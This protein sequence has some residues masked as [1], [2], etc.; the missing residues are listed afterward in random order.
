V[1]RDERPGRPALSFTPTLDVAAILHI[2]LDVYERRG[3]A[4]H[5]SEGRKRHRTIR[6]SLDDVAGTLT[7]YYNQTDPIPRTTANEQLTQLEER[8]MVRLSWRPGQTDHLLDA[9]ALESDQVEPLYTLLGREPLSDRRHRLHATLL[10][11]RFR[12]DDWR[13][14]AVQHCLDQLQAHKSVAPFNLND[15]DWNRDLL[16][17][18]IALPGVDV[19][20]EIPYRVFS[21]RV[22]ND[23]KRFDALKGA[24][25]RLARRHQPEWHALS[26]RET[27]REL[28]LVANPG[29]LYLYGPWRLVDPHGQV[30]SLSEFYPSVGIPTALAGR[31][32]Q[33]Q[34]NGFPT[35][36]VGTQAVPTNSVETQ[37]ARVVC[38]ENLAPFYELVRHK[39]HGLAALCLWGNPSPA[40]RHLLRCLAQDL[41]SGVSLFLWADI[42][43]GGLNILAQLREQVSPR[44]APYRMDCE[45]LE[46][47]AHWA[48]P[49]S[50]ADEHN[51]A[52]L[53]QHPLLVDMTPVIDHMLLRGVKLEQEAVALCT[54]PV[55]ML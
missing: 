6:V 4:P 11:D 39:G 24:I 49:L 44:I 41:P 51:L 47:H 18:L 50:S 3:G 22:F 54:N 43:Y 2:L 28:G 55:E 32:R 16:T 1:K 20:E 13:R 10:G 19:K 23:S 31:V 5:P 33:V 42:D 14:R 26:N 12:L 36:S 37:A 38:V 30:M 17:A 45:T 35:N 25:A 29:H 34:I 15:D 46:A 9:V 8:G 53:K 21:V 27:L 48:Q 7:G 52:R 40:S